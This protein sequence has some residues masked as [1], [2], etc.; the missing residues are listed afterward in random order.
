MERG[1]WR[2]G[3]AGLACAFAGGVIAGLLSRS[4]LPASLADTWRMLLPVV[5]GLLAIGFGL[6][7]MWTPAE[8]S[9]FSV[10]RGGLDGGDLR[11]SVPDR[12]LV[13]VAAAFFAGISAWMTQSAAEEA[14]A[15]T[16]TAEQTK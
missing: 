9:V 4:W 5:A 12:V 14:G 1:S 10:R 6:R 16:N 13:L 7:A 11:L 8:P 2:P 15:T 3:L